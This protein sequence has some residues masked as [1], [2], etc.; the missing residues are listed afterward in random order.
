MISG[1]RDEKIC[2]SDIVTR[3]RIVILDGHS[4]EIYALVVA[5]EKLF[6]TSCDGTIRVWMLGGFHHLRTVWINEYVPDI[7]PQC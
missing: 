2:I 5:G 4:C 7:A 3:K 6:S 1:A